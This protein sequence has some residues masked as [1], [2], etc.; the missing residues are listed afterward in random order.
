MAS[1]NNPSPDASGG[2]IVL[3]RVFA[4]PRDL[5]FRAW[6]EPAQLA[7]WWGPRGFTNPICE[8]EA[9]P[10]GKIYDVMRAPD[11]TDYPMGG[12]VIEV[13]APERLVFTTGALDEHGELLFEFSHS[14]TLTEAGGKTTLTLRSR[15]TMTK[16]GAEKYIGGFEA[17]MT[18]SWERL[19]EFVAPAADREI[20]IT[21]VLHAPR[22]LVWQAWT[23]PQ[24]VAHWWG[25]RGFTTTIKRMDF[26][27]GG[28]WEHVMRGPDG[29]NY[30]NKSIFKEIVPLE[31]ITYSH[32]GGREEGPGATFVATWT[33]ETVEGNKTR[34]TGRM[35]FPTAAAR[36]L[37]VREFGAIEGGKQTLER[38]SEYV[39]SLQTESFVLSREFDA[40]RDL[41]WRAWTEREQFAQWFGPKGVKVT[42]AKFDLRPGGLIHYSMKMPDGKEMWGKAVY[43]EVVPPTRLVWINSFSD[44]DA[45]IT[46]HPLTTDPWPLQ[47]LT[48]VT[49]AENAGKTTVTVN[50]LP[51]EADADERRVFDQGRESM[52]MGWGG[53][54]AQLEAHLATAHR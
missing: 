19:A 6:T 39:A 51:Y 35:I 42:L 22:E 53:T 16:P 43:R 25:P 34:L 26:R 32:G 47:M 7:Q 31:R 44:K 28:A 36:D 17:G 9:R 3:S 48:V 30:P 8:W 33:F 1:K 52:K 41:V 29:T 50:W 37:V 49:F 12:R 13:V 4:A 2:E 11:G 15:V 54:L 24:H 38:A 46:R 5:V 10:G 18:Q 45:G 21:R 40:P 27:V 14:L 20:V 23:D